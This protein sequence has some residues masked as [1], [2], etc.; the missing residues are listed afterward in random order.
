MIKHAKYL[1][2]LK[3]FLYLYLCDRSIQD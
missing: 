1:N 3:I 2:D